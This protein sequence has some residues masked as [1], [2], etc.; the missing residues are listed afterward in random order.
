MSTK[1]AFEKIFLRK[2]WRER[3]WNSGSWKNLAWYNL[4]R[5]VA[6]GMCDNLGFTYLTGDEKADAE[7]DLTNF[8]AFVSVV[9]GRK[10]KK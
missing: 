8:K 6:Q 2:E 9:D 4:G 10:K 5:S 7:L 1:A 3:K